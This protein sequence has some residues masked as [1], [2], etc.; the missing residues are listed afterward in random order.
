VPGQRVVLRRTVFG[1][2]LAL[3][4]LAGAG[5]ARA[6]GFDLP[7][8]GT[9]AIGRGAAFVAKADDPTAIYWN[10]AGLGRQRGTKILFYGNLYLHSFE[11]RRIG[12]YAGDPNSPETPWANAKYPATKNSAGPFALPFFA[13]SSD[14]GYFDRVTFGLGV[15]APSSIGNRT[16]PLGVDEKPAPSR[17]D[18]VQS[19]SSFYMPTG[20]VGIRVTPWLDLGISAHLVLGR[21]D[22]TSVLY[23]DAGPA[24]CKN[25]EFYKCDSRMTVQASGTGFGATIGALIRPKPSYAFGLSVRTPVTINAV[26]VVTPED[27]L[28]GEKAPEEGNA[29]FATQLPLLVKA[30]GRYIGMDQ[31]FELYDL[32]LNLTFENWGSSQGAGPILDAPDLGDYTNIKQVFIHNYTNTFGLRMGGAYNVDTG[33]GI[34]TVRGGAYYDGS[35][36]TFSNTRIDVD[37]LAKVAGTFGLGYKYSGFAVNL[38]YAAVASLP[39]VVGEGGIITPA[40]AL[41]QADPTG[42]EGDYGP[43]NQG[44]YRGFTHILSLGVTVQIDAFLGRPRPIPYGNPWEPGYS[45]ARSDDDPVKIEEEKQRKRAEQLR[46]IEQEKIDGSDKKDDDKTKDDDKKKDEE[47]KRDEERKRDEE[48]KKKPDDDIKKKP[49]DRD[50]PKK[51][52]DDKKKPKP[53]VEEEEEEDDPPPKKPVEPKKPIVTEVKA[54]PVVP[55]PPPPPPPPPKPPTKRKEWWEEPGQ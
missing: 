1:L 37:T 34:F 3:G 36:T 11:F 7:D 27:P 2:A 38:G 21:I 20:S 25:T 55:P 42:P 13:V 51:K 29:T 8:N 12:R 15:F 26:G 23:A 52:P 33:E 41:Q 10:P 47:K 24:T 9:Q 22:Q 16:F 5:E 43:V 45:G 40:N 32:E 28:V 54:P 49:D 48:T 39:R 35:S 6:G 46:N 44:A 4:S 14:F 31:D 17:Y 53:P 19:R 50:D 18:Y 30:G